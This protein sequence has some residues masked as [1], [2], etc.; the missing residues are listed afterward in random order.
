LV[1]EKVEADLQ[2]VTIAPS[3]P[4]KLPVISRFRAATG[5]TGESKNAV[6]REVAPVTVTVE[7][8]VKVVT[9]DVGALL[10]LIVTPPTSMIV[11][12]PKY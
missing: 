12:S 7:V 10:M 9:R 1:R 3:A 5:L 11:L 6:G 4:T 8:A 2:S